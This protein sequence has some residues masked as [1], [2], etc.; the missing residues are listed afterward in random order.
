MDWTKLLLE[1][2]VAGLLLATV[3]L[4]L[5]NMKGERVERI[6]MREGFLK[7]ITNHLDHAGQDQRATAVALQKLADAVEMQNNLLC[8]R[9][10]HEHVMENRAA[11]AAAVAAGDGRDRV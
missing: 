7:V 6:T 10:E 9:S 1:G 3:F 4:F 5:K 8:A 2:P 11:S